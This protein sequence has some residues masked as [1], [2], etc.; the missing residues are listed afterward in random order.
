MIKFGKFTQ[1]KNINE[2]QKIKIDTFVYEVR[3]I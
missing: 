3:I 1:N 2:I